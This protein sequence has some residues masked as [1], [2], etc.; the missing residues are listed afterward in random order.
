MI[1]NNINAPADIKAGVELVKKLNEKFIEKFGSI[2]CNQ[3]HCKL[4]GRT[5]YFSDSRD[6]QK[7][8]GAG[9]HDP[10]KKR[11]PYVWAKAAEWAVEV[12]EN[13]E[14]SGEY[15]RVLSKLK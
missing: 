7:F 13:F 6:F 4:Y 11:C 5:F 9:G 14:S 15:K 2:I 10:N 3:I 12:Y 8:L 1:G